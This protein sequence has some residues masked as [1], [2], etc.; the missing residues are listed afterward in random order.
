[1]RLAVTG[2]TGFV[3]QHLMRLAVA[4]GHSVAALA[5]SPQ[6][7]GPGVDWV[8]GDLL[9]P[10]IPDELCRGA[11]AVIHV[12]GII[13]PRR[14]AEFYE[15]NVGGTER[16][17]LAANRARVHRFIHVS[18][19]AAREPALSQYGASKAASEALFDGSGL[20]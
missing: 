5:R 2:G 7:P 14:P 19:L 15:A 6:S 8:M 20:A 18:S 11:D 17:I 13:N 1:M 3:G 9:A 12:G 16:M 10:V 4:A